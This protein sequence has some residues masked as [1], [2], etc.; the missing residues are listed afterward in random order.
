MGKIYESVSKSEI[1][2]P[3]Y[4]PEGY[5]YTYYTFSAR[6]DGAKHQISWEQFRKNIWK[7]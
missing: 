2:R 4:E 6:F 1:F 7:W 5:Y 3:Q